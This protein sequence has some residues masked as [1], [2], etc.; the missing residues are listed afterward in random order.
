MGC[1]RVMYIPDPIERMQANIDRLSDSYVEG[2]C[3][4]CGENVGEDNLLP[5]TSSP[6]APP[7][8]SECCDKSQ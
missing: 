8:C 2:C 5:Y 3:M 1:Y 7:A 6:D 4:I